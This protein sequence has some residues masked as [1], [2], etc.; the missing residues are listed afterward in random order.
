[1]IDAKRRPAA[2]I[3]T[4]VRGRQSHLDALVDGLTRQT[5]LTIELVIAYMQ[6]EPPSISE[7]LPF[8]VTL[9]CVRGEKLPL[10]AAR[11]AAAALAAS[12]R[13]IFLDV[14]CI[15][16]PQLVQSYIHQLDISGRCLLGE[17]RYLPGTLLKTE[18]T[19]ATFD[20]LAASAKQHPARPCLPDCGWIAEPEPRSLWG[21]S[22]ALTQAQYEASGG[23]DENY[24]G[25]GGEETDFAE[26]LAANG[27]KLGWCTNAL[28]L[29]QYHAVY[30]PPLD[31]FDDILSNAVRFY[32]K[33]GNWC[34]EYWLTHFV[35]YGL[36]EWCSSA[37]KIKVLRRPSQADISACR[38]PPEVAFA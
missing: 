23:M 1:M 35:D 9:V 27:I 10:A 11:N 14:D 13:L 37:T 15:P 26:Q 2:S 21:L 16:S 36:I 4:L 3:L 34:M 20:D 17:V 12:E 19:D 25:Y 31:K 18:S 29:H 24:E 32:G 6:P 7:A 38:Q 22:F 30:S 28:A 33:W 8:P 5:C